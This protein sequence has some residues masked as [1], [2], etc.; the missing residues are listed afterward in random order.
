MAIRDETPTEH[1]PEEYDQE[2]M[3]RALEDVY[4]RL[5]QLSRE[6]GSGL[7]E[8]LKSMSALSDRLN[9]AESAIRK[10]DIG[11]SATPPPITGLETY[12]I[13]LLPIV[14]AWCKPIN[15][16]KHK[17]LGGY[18]FF[19]S[20]V[21]NFEALEESGL[22]TFTGTAYSTHA[23]N[24][25]VC[26]TAS[27]RLHKTTADTNMQFFAFMSAGNSKTIR[28]VT[29][30]TE[31]TTQSWSKNT[32]KTLVTDIAWNAGDTYEFETWV[33]KN[34]VHQGPLPYA[35]FY[36]SNWVGNPGW[37]KETVYVK[38]RTYT[39]GRRSYSKFDSA[40]T[41]GNDGE[42][43]GAPTVTAKPIFWNGNVRVSWT[44]GIG[45][46]DWWDEL[47]HY[48]L[49]RTTA[50]D[51][52]MLTDSNIIYSGRK[53]VH[54]DV[55]YDATNNP[56]GP[57]QGKTYYYWCVCVNKEGE[58]GT[59]SSADPASLTV[60]G[61]VTIY[62][63]DEEET[64]SFFNVKNW[65]IYWYDD[66]DSEG[67]WVRLRRDLGGG[68]YGLWSA[69][70]YVRFTTDNGTHASG[71]Y[72]QKYTFHNLQVGQDY[73]AAVKATNNPFVPDLGGS[74]VTHDFTVTD[75]ASPSTPT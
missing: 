54:I 27:T 63:D 19:A 15:P 32:P 29:T 75:S 20:M 36:I 44:I 57:V 8:A 51:T 56:D 1:I 53:L 45:W 33:P 5:N 62:S 13:P 2:V 26:A 21:H 12:K 48:S 17:E 71:Y 43:L 14:V 22:V 11:T 40:S 16:I 35:V 68:S 50:N 37:D 61:T 10:N 52:A 39:R 7:A 59:F 18:Q 31:G 73:Q 47:D 60:G 4:R 66:G 64:K 46:K 9:D 24:L 28:N 65:N 6:G 69:P 3:T 58:N 30:D 38:A 42:T 70:I 23:T 74:W 34:L 49:Y 41:T 55:G 67:Y 25:V 72:I